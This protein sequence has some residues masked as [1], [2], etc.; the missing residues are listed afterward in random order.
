[1]GDCPVGRSDRFPFL[2]DPFH[3]DFCDETDGVIPVSLLFMVV[4]SLIWPLRHHLRLG[5]SYTPMLASSQ[6]EQRKCQHSIFHIYEW[7]MAVMTNY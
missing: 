6:K 3:E 5:N 1:L 7:L 2:I 4:K